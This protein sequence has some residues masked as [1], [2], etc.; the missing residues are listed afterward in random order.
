MNYYVHSV[1]DYI[2]EQVNKFRT[3]GNTHGRLLIGIPSLPAAET[4]DLGKLLWESCHQMDVQFSF[5]V[6]AAQLKEWDDSAAE[7]EVKQHGWLAAGSLTSD[8]NTIADGS[9]S[10]HL[11]IL[12]GTETVT[13]SGSLADFH[14]CDATTIWSAGM[15]QSFN[16]WTKRALDARQIAYDHKALEDFDTVL[17]AMRNKYGMLLLG[18]LLGVI[19]FQSQDGRGAVKELLRSLDVFGLPN[20]SGHKFTRTETSIFFVLPR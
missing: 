10:C 2:N 13:D 7:Q 17:S 6:A 16:I 4:L 11:T 12:V 18:D 9:D 19:K 1:V 3:A 20:M 15:Q 14:S 5:K 8:R